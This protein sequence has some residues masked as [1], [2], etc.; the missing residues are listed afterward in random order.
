[1]YCPTMIH[2]MSL[3]VEGSEYAVLKEYFRQLTVQNTIQRIVSLTVEHNFRPDRSEI[4][5]LLEENDYVFVKE[6]CQDDLYVHASFYPLI[7]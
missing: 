4:R 6:L 1:M 7:P 2:Y 3:D 5:T